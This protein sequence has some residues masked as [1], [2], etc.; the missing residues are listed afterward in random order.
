MAKR[1]FVATSGSRGDVEPFLALSKALQRAGYDVLL[2]APPDFG[3]WIAS[4][5][6]AHHPAGEPAREIVY[7]FAD[8]IEN[9]KFFR[10][11][12]RA[13]YE[14]KFR[15]LFESV[16]EASQ[17][18][19]L[20]IY[21]PL[22]AS[23][24]FLAEARGI[25]AIAVYLAPAFPTAE[26]AV[27]LMRRFSYG[28]FVNPLLHRALDLLLWN[29]FRP[30]WNSVRSGLP[31]LKPLGRFHDIHSINGKPILHLFALS[32]TLL[33]RPRDWPG[34]AIMT[35]NFFLDGGEDWQVPADL[36]A[37][38]EAGP[39]PIYIGFGS[40]PLG[41]SKTKARILL[42]A[43]RLSGQRV[44]MA[45]GWGGWGDEFTESLGTSLHLID[46][47]P[48]RRLFPL[49]AGV[50]HHGGA[51]TTAASV[52][53]GRPSLVTPLMMDQ[54]FFANLIAR[55]GAG[56][57]PL[58]V[59]QWRA[60]ILAGRL[61]ELTRVPDYARRAGELAARMSQENG[62]ARALQAVMDVIGSP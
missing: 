31:G 42:E 57:Q 10:S 4:H 8:A 7:A 1:I 39:P 14:Q 20:L 24:T 19:A 17:G 12:A 25:P 26:F 62:Q 29:M 13:G 33:P 46:A 22:M 49:M 2:S 21:S 43:L 56:P 44:V 15:A 52:L 28:S 53:A 47:A 37:F 3:G 35:G 18:A 38:L 36:A 59:K 32:E 30:W 6:I 11:L 27:P 34:H 23:V 60:D 40:M 54:H 55:H 5:G 58:P 9:D 41:Q 61:A 50:V 51:G 16:A 48:H 45:R